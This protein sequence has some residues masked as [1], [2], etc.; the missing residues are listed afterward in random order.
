[1]TANGN[2]TGGH[3]ERIEDFDAIVALHY[4]KVRINGKEYTIRPVTALVQRHARELRKEM[5]AGTEMTAGEFAARLAPRCLDPRPSTEEAEAMPTA[6][7]ELVM[8]RASK[9]LSAM[10]RVLDEG[11]EKNEGAPVPVAQTASPS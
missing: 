7:L 1:M 2:G 9:G 11:P 3:S 4:G 5:E 6:V 8:E 10:E